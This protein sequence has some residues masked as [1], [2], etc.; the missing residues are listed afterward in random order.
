VCH[1]HPPYCTGFAVAG[2][3]LDRPV[4]P[5]FVVALGDVPLA[6]YAPPSTPDLGESVKPYI[7]DHDVF[8]LANHGALAIGQ[9]VYQAYHRMETMEMSAHVMFIARML[10][11][12]N[13]ISADELPHLRNMRKSMGL[14]Y[15]RECLTFPPGKSSP[16]N[17]GDDVNE[18]TVEAV[19]RRVAER[20]IKE[21]SR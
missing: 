17:R 18:A 4:L 21:M 2:E 6:P 8:L 12:L 16:V 15:P 1:A 13:E 3:P 9:D 11:R 19:V 14:D 5:E 20:L 7:R 10:G